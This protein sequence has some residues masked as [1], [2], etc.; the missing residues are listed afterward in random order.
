MF[1]NGEKLWNKDRYAID[2]SL[3]REPTGPRVFCCRDVGETT[4]GNLAG[5]DI[6]QGTSL[7]PEDKTRYLEIAS[8]VYARVDGAY[9]IVGSSVISSAN[10]MPTVSTDL[11]IDPITGS[12]G[13]IRTIHRVIHEGTLYSVSYKSPDDTPIA[14]NGT[15]VLVL[16]MGSEY[17]HMI[18][19]AAFGGDGEV[20]FYEGPGIDADGIP[21]TPQN[22]K[23][24]DARL[25]DMTV[26]RDPTVNTDGLLL[27]DKLSPGGTKQAAIG[28][29]GLD[30]HEWIF[31]PATKYMIRLTNRAATAQPMS[32][33]A[34][35]Y[36]EET[37]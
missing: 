23:R 5:K 31:Q 36:E 6:A 20:E 14:D 30:R 11:A 29:A 7:R 8:G 15:I 4:G 10:P 16:S 28:A 37:N 25:S 13:T 3:T 1:R 12:L 2:L 34:Y 26:V 18:A 32:V 22:H 19:E 35:W 9:V 17:A 33:S 24:T 27:A 21:V